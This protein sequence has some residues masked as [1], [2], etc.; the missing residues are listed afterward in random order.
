M[1]MNIE[2][3]IYPYIKLFDA[4]ISFCMSGLHVRAPNASIALKTIEFRP[5]LEPLP[6]PKNPNV[7]NL[8]FLDLDIRVDV[9]S[10]ETSW[11][12]YDK[13]AEYNFRT[14]FK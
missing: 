3:Y 13:R 9:S 11:S 2:I 4:A 8:H 12:T 7:R 1:Y 5:R 6:D 14:I 10:G